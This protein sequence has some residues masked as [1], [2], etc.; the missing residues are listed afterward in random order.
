MVGIVKILAQSRCTHGCSKSVS[1]DESLIILGNGP[2]LNDSIRDDMDILRTHA[3]MAVNFAANSDEYLRL[4]P[5][6]YILADP[7]FFTAHGAD[8]NVTRL[9]ER[10]ASLTDWQMTL[11]VPAAYVKISPCRHPMN[12]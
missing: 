10:I 8:N 11:F 2:S 4:R 1:K 9:F 5:R 3:C 6:Y 12:T 7:H